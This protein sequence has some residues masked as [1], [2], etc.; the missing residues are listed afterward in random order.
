MTVGSL[1]SAGTPGADDTTGWQDDAVA[2]RIPFKTVLTATLLGLIGRWV[3]SQP[4]PRTSDAP[5][6]AATAAV[7]AASPSPSD[8]AV[9][10]SPPATDPVQP[11]PL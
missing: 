8:P 7:A 6:T 3:L 1:L 2:G 4:T 5:A 11:S 9:P 10:V